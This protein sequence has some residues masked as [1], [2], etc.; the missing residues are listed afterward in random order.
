MQIYLE[1]SLARLHQIIRK[2]LQDA[3][4]QNH[5]VAASPDSA[6]P[7]SSDPIMYGNNGNGLKKK[8]RRRVKHDENRTEGHALCQTR[9]RVSPRPEALTHPS[10]GACLLHLGHLPVITEARPALC[11]P[12][13]T[14]L[15]FTVHDRSVDLPAGI[16]KRYREGGNLRFSAKRISGSTFLE[17]QA[18]P[19]LM[20]VTGLFLGPGGAQQG[21]SV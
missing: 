1:P 3:S 9:G 18:Q 7:R 2:D 6:R 19:C 13:I 21:L 17:H 4:Q 15:Y 5:Q 10:L 11:D 12:W 8:L 14:L 16:F 20:F